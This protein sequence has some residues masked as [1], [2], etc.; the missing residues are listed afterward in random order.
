[1]GKILI[2]EDDSSIRSIIRIN[3]IR[4][5]YDV[6][7][8]KTG[9]S[10]K[11]IVEENSD[12]MIAILD[13]MLPG[14]SGLELCEYIKTINTN[15]G[16]IML[17]ARVQEKD[18]I[19]GLDKGADDYMTKPF[20]P[21]ELMARVNALSRRVQSSE[22]KMIEAILKKPPFELNIG[23]RQC[24]KHGE[25]IILTP[26][27][28]MIVKLFLESDGQTLSRNDLLNKIWGENFF[29]DMKIVDVNI[30]RLRRKIEDNPSKPMFI[31]TVWG[32]GYKWDE[33]LSK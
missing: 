8:A 7:E 12:I 26:T 21:A 14:I 30:R 11:S 23:T 3:L 28:F 27:E 13:I 19:L 6:I 22:K 5:G 4:N 18:K 20:S 17:T 31:Q 25:E 1:M 10:A 9:E 15:M 33:K 24:F 29:G 2:V 16:I 32:K